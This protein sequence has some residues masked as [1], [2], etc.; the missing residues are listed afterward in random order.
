MSRSFTDIA[1]STPKHKKKLFAGGEEDQE[2]SE[3]LFL[4]NIKGD[5]NGNLKV[6]SSC[7]LNENE[8]EYK[9]L[10][11]DLLDVKLQMEAEKNQNGVMF[12]G[13]RNP[14]PIMETPVRG[15]PKQLHD[16]NSNHLTNNNKLFDSN[17]SMFC[18]FQSGNSTQA[19]MNFLDETGSIYSSDTVC[20]SPSFIE[21]SIRLTDMQ[22]GLETIGRELA[23][24]YNIKWRENWPFLGTGSYIDIR[25]D[26]GLVMFENYLKQKEKQQ[27]MNEANTSGQLSSRSKKLDD[28][29][30]LGAVCAG[31]YSM[32]LND[33]SNKITK[34]GLTSPTSPIS[35]QSLF[36]GFSSPQQNSLSNSPLPNPYIC[37]EQSCR[38]LSKRLTSLLES[39]TIQD[40]HS[41]EKMLLQE[42][43]K[44]NK[45]IDNYKRDLRFTKVNFQK[46]HAR[47]S[48]LLVWYLKK[49]NVDVKYLRNFTP[50]IHKVYALASQFATPNSFES[51]K[52]VSKNHAICVSSFISNYI[53]KQNKIFNPEN[54]DTEIACIDAWNGP[55]IVEC[56]CSLGMNP[57]NSKHRREIRKKLYSGKIY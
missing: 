48:F 3:L 51:N 19:A 44:L 38:A 34:N 25:T 5:T 27:E 32:D 53:E 50:L 17:D 40:Q 57:S 37:I 35:R 7:I 36:N 54:V 22:K 31:F 49:N 39:E 18:N 52:D 16:N 24:E 20:D 9:E 1:S 4:D 56:S 47:Y 46:V 8:E 45:S 43:G 28:S 26:E 41:Y 55:D 30:G 13:Y 42:I 29:F 2:E 33:K 11:D 12:N 14:Q 15:K 21:R 6:I 23:R 10:F